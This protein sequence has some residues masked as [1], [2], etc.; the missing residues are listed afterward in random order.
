MNTRADAVSLRDIGKTYRRGKEKIEVLHHLDLSVPSG[1]FLAL[2]GPSGSGKTTVLNLIGGLDH[3]DSGEVV[4]AGEALTMYS[5]VSAERSR[6][7]RC[8][9]SALARERLWRP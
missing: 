7:P 3:P 4:V 6:S 9:R 2:M 1:E 8:E 5:A